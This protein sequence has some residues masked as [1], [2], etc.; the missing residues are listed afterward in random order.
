M[1]QQLIHVRC[2]AS[3][4]RY[5]SDVGG[6]PSDKD[7]TSKSVLGK[8]Q[9][10]EMSVSF[11]SS[12]LDYHTGDGSRRR[13]YVSKLSELF[14]NRSYAVCPSTGNRGPYKK[15]VKRIEPTENE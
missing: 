7:R 11:E 15:R 4:V 14:S 10:H 8:R 6:M 2:S 5:R 13:T 12:F 3:F 9:L 1:A